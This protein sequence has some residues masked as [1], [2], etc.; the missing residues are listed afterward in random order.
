MINKINFDGSKNSDGLLISSSNQNNSLKNYFRISQPTR[1]IISNIGMIMY[2]NIWY[3]YLFDLIDQGFD[4]NNR[5]ISTSIFFGPLK[6]DKIQYNKSMLYFMLYNWV[7]FRKNITVGDR[8]SNDW[9]FAPDTIK[10]RNSNNSY[11]LELCDKI[12][13]K[14]NLSYEDL[15]RLFGYQFKDR[16]EKKYGASKFKDESDKFIK[17]LNKSD[18]KLDKIELFTKFIANQVLSI[19]SNEELTY[20][21][22]VILPNLNFIKEN[23]NY[24]EKDY[25]LLI[26]NQNL[27]NFEFSKEERST[28][29]SMLA[30][31]T[32]GKLLL[33]S[34]ILFDT[35]KNNNITQYTNI[36][37][38]RDISQISNVLD[39]V[40]IKNILANK[41]SSK[42]VFSES[43]YYTLILNWQ[44]NLFLYYGERIIREILNEIDSDEAILKNKIKDSLENK[45]EY[46]IVLKIYNFLRKEKHILE[47]SSIYKDTRQDS[48]I[49]LLENS[50]SLFELFLDRLFK[51]GNIEY[52][53]DGTINFTDLS[54]D[55]LSAPMFTGIDNFFSWCEEFLI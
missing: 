26:T 39:S 50:K 23:F 43:D 27:F 30:K 7:E 5:I 49:P 33:Q 54:E 31:T 21:G 15:W 20:K 40:N 48:F 45:T 34:F 18:S 2:D 32:N 41:F 24:N 28:F 29:L 38:N 55:E 25:A 1:N 22:L 11:L 42:Y 52:N 10:D 14:S 35:L 47:L 12:L 51:N 53:P 37:K 6:N 36:V 44:Y 46:S 13:D 17:I 3:K 19:Y 9:L 4:L 16:Y 8:W